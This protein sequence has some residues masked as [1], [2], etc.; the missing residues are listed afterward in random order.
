MNRA[1][2]SQARADNVQVDVHTPAASP[3]Q[4]PRRRRVGRSAVLA[5]LVAALAL[6]V[7][8]WLVFGRGGDPSPGPL[9]SPEAS[10]I[11]IGRTAGEPFG[12]GLTLAWNTGDRPAVLER[13]EPV[14]PTPGLRV[15]A[16]GAAG[17]EREFLFVAS[18]QTWPSDE[19]TDLHPV[20]GF[21]V[22][23]RASAAGER[24]VELVL[25]LQADKPGRY[26][27]KAVAVEYTVDGE[28]HRAII[29]NGIGVCV[30]PPGERTVR[31]CDAPS[32]LTE[33]Q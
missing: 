24:G 13:I 33:N 18:T 31:G 22:A 9:S 27:F 14:D 17:P 20:R 19:F 21:E 15:V 16:T 2:C 7:M 12:F 5:V 4:A 28:R 32:G 23:P 8:L 26:V 3:P 1:A 11:G 10:R 6:V 29:R 25:A 30:T